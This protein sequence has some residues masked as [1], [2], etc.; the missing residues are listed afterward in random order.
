MVFKCIF[1]NYFPGAKLTKKYL[2]FHKNCLKFVGFCT[3]NVI[4]NTSPVDP[5]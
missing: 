5:V 1:Y 4:N 3:I 2:K